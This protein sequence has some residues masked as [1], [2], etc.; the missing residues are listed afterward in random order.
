[1]LP[2]QE[3]IRFSEY[4]ALYDIVV[5]KDNKWRLLND[6]VDYSFVYDELKDKY[7]PNNGRM[8]EDP[9]RMFKY[10]MLKSVLGL[11]DVDLVDRCMSDMA[12]KYFLG[13]APEDNVIDSSTLSK[14]R[15]QRLKDV[16]LLDILIGKSIETARKKGIEI[17]RKII[18]DST[19]TLSRLN[20]GRPASA[21]QKQAK[22]LRK[23]VYE[24]DGRMSGTLPEKYEGTDLEQEMDYVAR[25]L[26]FLREQPVSQLPVVSEKMNLL[27]EMVEDI[28][29]H[30]T[31]S[32]DPDARMGHKSSDSEFFG[33]K[34]HL[35]VTPERLVV[36]ATMTSGEKGDGPELP[37]LIR[38]AKVHIPDLEEVIGDGAYSGQDNLEN[39]AKE[40]VNLIAK[41]N[42]VVA[43]GNRKE[44]GF[45]YNKDAGMMV[46]PAGHMATKAN[47][48]RLRYRGK[49]DRLVF[50]F[51]IHKCRVCSHSE[52]CGFP[53]K[54][55]QGKRYSVVIMTKE[56]E[57]Q[58]KAQETE[59][60]KSEYGLRYIVEAKNAELKHSYHLDKTISIGLD[61]YTLQGA[62]ALYTSNL[63]RILRIMG[64]KS[65]K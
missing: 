26:S 35:A 21:L 28:R 15:R 4:S 62:V 38:K 29:D 9:V 56:Q 55:R 27:A 31:V 54:G 5:K 3:K 19:H 44:D 51:D 7:C 14:F 17:S 2:I 34:G 1:M 39:A 63:V 58:R 10:L 60:F 47:K 36:A 57:S 22:I 41:L 40:D 12:C 42:P 25:L 23:A 45:Q 61:M 16:N 52:Q 13:L 59:V 48:V 8:A 20:P 49:N 24:A 65:G 30:Y 33:Y 46:C 6:L 18:V 64:E 43:N 32:M 53:W 11:S 37:E 50:T